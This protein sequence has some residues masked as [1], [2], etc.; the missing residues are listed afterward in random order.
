MPI[1]PR[2]IFY[3]LEADYRV[4]PH[5]CWARK[6][7][8]MQKKGSSPVHP[9]EYSLDNPQ[10][11]SNIIGFGEKSVALTIHKKS[12]NDCLVLGRVYKVDYAYRRGYI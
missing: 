10:Q 9:K 4:P 11:L 7:V 8:F 5:Q 1:Y 2:P 12:S 6:G 3:L